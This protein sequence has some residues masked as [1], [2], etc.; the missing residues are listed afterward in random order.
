MKKPYLLLAIFAFIFIQ[1]CS[2]EEAIRVTDVNEPKL[3]STVH[4]YYSG[5]NTKN[6]IATLGRVLFYD[7]LLSKNNSVS[8]GSCHKQAFAFSDNVQFSVGLNNV[9]TERNSM[10]IQNLPTGTFFAGGIGNGTGDGFGMNPVDLIMVQG[11]G[12][13]WDGRESNLRS[14]FSR[15]IT[16]HIEMGITDMDE[17][18][19]KISRQPH[20]ATL[21]QNAFETPEI[22][23]TRMA[24]AVATFME[25]IQSNNSTFDRFMMN[26]FNPMS[27]DEQDGYNLFFGTYNCGSCHNPFPGP[28]FT[29]VPKDIGLESNPIDLGFG[30]ITGK[31]ELMGKFKTPNLKN[32]ALTAPYMHDGRF[33]SLDEVLEHYSNGIQSSTNLDPVLKDQY[34]NPSK[35]NITEKDKKSLKAFL[36]A[37]TD[38]SIVT[39]VKFSDPFVK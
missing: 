2:K 25:S 19:E 9:K 34:G 33:K 26:S 10:A 23:V 29:D 17:V 6:H 30:G 13:F 22:N 24:E 28:Y 27:A 35:M 14:L 32:V 21:F 37:L 8:C 16:N 15:P 1:S 38:Y 12:F 11:G 7:R 31:A 39:D 3:P 20:Y 5:D 36:N 4:N 18:V